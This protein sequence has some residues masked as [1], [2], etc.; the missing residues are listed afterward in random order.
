MHPREHDGFKIVDVVV[1][2]YAKAPQ[3]RSFSLPVLCGWQGRLTKQLFPI[4]VL[5]FVDSELV[6]LR[7]GAVSLCRQSSLAQG[8]TLSMCWAMQPG[9]LRPACA[10]L[11]PPEQAFGERDVSLLSKLREARPPTDRARS[12]AR[13]LNSL[14][15]LV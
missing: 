9:F 13:F 5:P 6:S 4:L 7:Q 15:A 3:V 14:G 1:T 10:E 11:C 2:Q 12:F 8:R